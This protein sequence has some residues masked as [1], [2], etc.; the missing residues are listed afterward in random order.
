MVLTERSFAGCVA[1]IAARG[2]IGNQES[3][4]DTRND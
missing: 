4:G 3:D 2:S 1:R